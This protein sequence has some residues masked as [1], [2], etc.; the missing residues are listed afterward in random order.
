ME[1]IGIQDIFS[2]FQESPLGEK[3]KTLDTLKIVY[4]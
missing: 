3:N 4:F 2:I 1:E